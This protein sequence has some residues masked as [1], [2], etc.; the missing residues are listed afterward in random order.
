[1]R[2]L[3]SVVDEYAIK[4]DKNRLPKLVLEDFIHCGLEC[5]R[6]I[7]DPERHDMEFEVPDMCVES[8][9][10]NCIVHHPNRVKAWLKNSFRKVPCT[11]QFIK[12]FIDG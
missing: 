3:V 6:G 7:V 1:M 8:R 10:Q 9:L 11:I 2:G 12:N 5:R 4:E